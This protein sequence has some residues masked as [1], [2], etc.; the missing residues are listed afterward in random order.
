MLVSWDFLNCSCSFTAN[1]IYPRLLDCQNSLLLECSREFRYE[2]G[3]DTMT[4]RVVDLAI[5]DILN[6]K[7]TE[8]FNKRLPIFA[9]LVCG[10]RTFF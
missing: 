3:K 9:N 7:N 4:K 8:K 5:T 2:L 1:S 6:N 10:V